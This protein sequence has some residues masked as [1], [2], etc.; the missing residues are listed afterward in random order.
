MKERS[1]KIADLLR[2][3][4]SVQA[5]GSAD[6]AL[7]VA[8]SASE[9]APE[10]PHLGDDA[11]LFDRLR[12]LRRDLALER[13][14]PPYIVCSDKTLRGICRLRPSSR[15]ELLDVPGIG[16]AKLQEYGEALLGAVA[17]FEAEA[18]ADETR[19]TTK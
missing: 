2:D 5:A 8:A 6:G 14:V 17:A 3:E 9:T 16:E 11:E 13:G 10:R 1:R 4:E 12:V 18:A 7:G 19:R 15:E